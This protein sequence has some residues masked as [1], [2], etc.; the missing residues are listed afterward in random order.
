VLSLTA[1]ARA[2]LEQL[3]RQ[4]PRLFDEVCEVPPERC[5]PHEWF[6]D[7]RELAVPYDCLT[8]MR[9]LHAELFDASWHGRHSQVR[10][11]VPCG[12]Q[13][14]GNSAKGLKPMRSLWTTVEVTVFSE[15]RSRA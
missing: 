5:N 12:E 11:R 2:N 14:W 8:V 1:A 3:R 4:D 13:G 10:E 9:L 7:I 15:G 6:D